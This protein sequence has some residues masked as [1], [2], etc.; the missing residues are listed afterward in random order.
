MNEGEIKGGFFIKKRK[1]K[2]KQDQHSLIY[3]VVRISSSFIMKFKRQTYLFVLLTLKTVKRVVCYRVK[4]DIFL[5]SYFFSPF[6]SLQLI[7]IIYRCYRRHFFTYVSLSA[8]MRQLFADFSLLHIVIVLLL[9]KDSN[10]QSK[11]MVTLS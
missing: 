4:Q 3:I 9:F 8:F 5:L 6:S 11:K 2:L 7:Y 10:R 1:K